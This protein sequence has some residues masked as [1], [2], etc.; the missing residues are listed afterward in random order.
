MTAQ[1]AP[2]EVSNVAPQSFSYWGIA[3]AELLICPKTIFVE[4]D[5]T[6]RFEVPFSLWTFGK[7][8]SRSTRL[9]VEQFPYRGWTLFFG[10]SNFSAEVELLELNR[11]FSV[12]LL[13][14]FFCVSILSKSVPWIPSKNSALGSSLV[15][16]AFTNKKRSAS[17]NVKTLENEVWN[18]YSAPS[19]LVH[20]C[21]SVN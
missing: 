21:K 7:V 5:R 11:T 16:F 15:D 18:F 10:T 8:G 1:S 3:T 13:A 6:D 14:P 12:L 4:V 20:R 19:T 17:L 2:C 9:G